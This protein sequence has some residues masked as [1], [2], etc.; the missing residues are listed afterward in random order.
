[1]TQTRN[2]FHK[3]KDRFVRYFSTVKKILLNMDRVKYLLVVN[4][5][6]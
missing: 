1:M 6:K 5:K 3:K 2:V 4:L